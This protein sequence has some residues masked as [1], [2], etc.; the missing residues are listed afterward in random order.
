MP[1]Q[2]LLSAQYN[3]CQSGIEEG[4]GIDGVAVEAGPVEGAAEHVQHHVRGP[5]QSSHHW[6][7][8]GDGR[9]RWVRYWHAAYR[10]RVVIHPI[11]IPK[12]K[13]QTIHMLMD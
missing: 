1:R 7:R 6:L 5:R 8:V 3:A 13:I 12:T 4:G 9:R 2:H 11:E 10:V